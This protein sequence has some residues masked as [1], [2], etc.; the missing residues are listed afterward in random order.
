MFDWFTLRELQLDKDGL[1]RSNSGGQ[2][3]PVS[4][5]FVVYVPSAFGHAKLYSPERP[6]MFVN[7]ML[8]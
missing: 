4:R 6:E 5:Y 2:P 1:S 7:Y 8:T 3:L